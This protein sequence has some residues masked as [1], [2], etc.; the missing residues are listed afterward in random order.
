MAPTYAVPGL[1]I[2]IVKAALESYKMFPSWLPEFSMFRKKLACK[3]PCG[4]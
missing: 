3:F 4:M 1:L 2:Q